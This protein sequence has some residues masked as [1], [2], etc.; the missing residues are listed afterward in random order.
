LRR[1]NGCRPLGRPWIRG[2]TRPRICRSRGCGRRGR[3][4]STNTWEPARWNRPSWLASLGWLTADPRGPDGCRRRC[5]RTARP[6]QR[7]PGAVWR[8]EGSSRLYGSRWFRQRCRATASRK[9]SQPRRTR[10]KSSRPSLL[11]RSRL[12]S[13]PS[14]RSCG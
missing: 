9:T 2:E 8:T 6:R 13:K 10:R 11:A 7:C 4:R 5:R 14:W 3:R 12:P 1:A